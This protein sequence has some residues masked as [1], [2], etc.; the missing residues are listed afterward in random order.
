VKT[1]VSSRNNATP[2]L[3]SLTTLLPFIYNDEAAAKNAAP[4]WQSF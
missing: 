3:G 1:D 2:R 4:D